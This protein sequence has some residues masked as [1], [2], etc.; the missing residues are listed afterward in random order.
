MP[1]LWPRKVH[2][3]REVS[4][5]ER[6]FFQRASTENRRKSCSNVNKLVIQEKWYLAPRRA[7]QYEA[8]KTLLGTLE[9]RRQPL[10]VERLVAAAR[11]VNETRM[12]KGSRICSEES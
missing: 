11:P 4:S 1:H 12:E 8:M 2:V 5:R 6:E 7:A 9:S 3:L 10:F